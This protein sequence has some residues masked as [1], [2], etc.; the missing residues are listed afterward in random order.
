M[1]SSNLNL[2]SSSRKT[3]AS[4]PGGKSGKKHLTLYSIIPTN[5]EYLVEPFAGLA[6]FFFTIQSSVKMVWLNDININVYSLL[7]IIKNDNLL[8][9]L[10][11]KLEN[12]YPIEKEDYYFWKERKTEDEIENALQLIIIL[13]CS[14]NGAGGGYSFEKAHRKWHINK[15]KIWKELSQLLQKAKITNKDYKDV[16]FELKEENLSNT[17]IY[18]DPPYHTVA[19]NGRLYSI[20]ND[21]DWNEFKSLLDSIETHWIMSNRDNQQVRAIFDEYHMKSYNTYNDMNNKGKKNPEL[22]ISNKKFKIYRK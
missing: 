7:N 17:L 1:F 3:I 20:Y 21:I 22:I 12:I 6:N 11:N 9:T 15:P 13:N 4:F 18:L 16:L 10:I 14:P 5:I 8:N 2:F 19:Q